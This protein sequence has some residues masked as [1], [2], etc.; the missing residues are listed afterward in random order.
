MLGEKRD[1]HIFFSCD[2]V[3][4]ITITNATGS[5]YDPPD[6]IIILL[7]IAAEFNRLSRIRRCVNIL[8]NSKP[9]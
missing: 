8:R 6:K 7:K 5:K 4:S 2:S 9:R 3:T 1:Y